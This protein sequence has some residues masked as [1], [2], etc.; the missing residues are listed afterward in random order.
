MEV[1]PCKYP[2][3]KSGIKGTVTYP[4]TQSQQQLMATPQQKS[5]K[6][7]KLNSE[8]IGGNNIIMKESEVSSKFL[9]YK[10][11]NKIEDNFHMNN[12]K[13]LYLNMKN[14]YDALNED[15]FE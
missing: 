15:V 6:K 14:Y 1:L 10:L 12:K 11:Y 3:K 5:N 13:A 4:K 7:K 2:Y 8:K 9:D